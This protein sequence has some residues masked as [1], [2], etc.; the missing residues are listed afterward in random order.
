MGSIYWTYIGNYLLANEQ[1]DLGIGFYIPSNRF[2]ISDDDMIR[3]ANLAQDTC[4]V[5]PSWYECVG[6]G[7]LP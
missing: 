5:D 3:I 4:E 6:D 7:N 1:Y 2:T